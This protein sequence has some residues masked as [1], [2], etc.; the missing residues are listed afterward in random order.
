MKIREFLTVSA[1]GSMVVTVAVAIQVVV[2]F[3]TQVTFARI[4]APEVF[5]QLAYATTIA[6]LFN[7]MTNMRGDAYVVHQKDSTEHALDI[8]FTLELIV[9]TVFVLFVVLMAPFAMR[10]LGKGEL[11]LYVQILAFLFFY[12]SFSRTRS[13]FER[14]LSFAYSK[15]PSIVSQL[16]L[17]N[18]LWIH[19]VDQERSP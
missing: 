13:L 7:A 14:N 6:M 3:V 1:K 16:Q 9:A 11:T 4:L 12:N 8:V 2:G 10:L 5:G 19:F 17:W 15:T 18:F